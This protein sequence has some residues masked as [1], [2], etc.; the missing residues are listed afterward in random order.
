MQSEI[1]EL[2][3]KTLSLFDEWTNLLKEHDLVKLTPNTM[4][5]LAIFVSERLDQ[6]HKRIE[7]LEKDKEE[8]E[9]FR[10]LQNERGY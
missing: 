7:V 2:K 8:E 5:S 1:E 10:K 6:L 9:A 3:Q 4:T